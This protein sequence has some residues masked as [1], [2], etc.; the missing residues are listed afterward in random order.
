MGADIAYAKP[1][2]DHHFYNAEDVEELLDRAKLMKANIVTTSKDFVRLMG[3]GKAQT[4]LAKKLKVVNVQL[5]FDDNR[6]PD[7]LIDETIQRFDKRM[8][9]IEVVEPSN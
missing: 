1:F 5:A 3:T 2:S 4:K 6:T 9:N 7:M 8:L